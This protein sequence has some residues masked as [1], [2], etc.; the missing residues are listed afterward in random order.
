MQPNGRI[1][2]GAEAAL[3]YQAELLSELGIVAVERMG[4]E[5]QMVGKQT[6]IA[7]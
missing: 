3:H 7:V 6:G 4:I 2:S 5:W 1:T